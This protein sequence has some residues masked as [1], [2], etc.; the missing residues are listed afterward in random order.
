MAAPI[1]NEYYK[2][3]K[4]DAPGS[5]R[6]RSEITGKIFVLGSKCLAFMEEVMN[7]PDKY[8]DKTK[9]EICKIIMLKIAPDLTSSVGE[10][11]LER[12]DERVKQFITQRFGNVEP[13]QIVAPGKQDNVTTGEM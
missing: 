11:W 2:L 3:R 5:G 1:G 10:D 12:Y 9:M 7:R 6:Q 4:T 13:L 8:S